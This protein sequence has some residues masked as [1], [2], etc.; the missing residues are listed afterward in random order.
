MSQ[1]PTTSSPSSPAAPAHGRAPTVSIKALRAAELATVDWRFRYGVLLLV[2]TALCVT[3][4]VSGSVA[5]DVPMQVVE[6]APPV[7]LTA[8]KGAAGPAAVPS[9]P[10]ARE[11]ALRDAA[12]VA[13]G[14]N[15][16]VAAAATKAP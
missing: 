4:A 8:D 7:L 16:P 13:Q 2:L 9:V 1:L 3:L 11:P 15:V 10:S 6:V 12:V 14:V 5:P